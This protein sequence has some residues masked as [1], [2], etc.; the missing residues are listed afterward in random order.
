MYLGEENDSGCIY[1]YLTYAYGILHGS[2]WD[3]YE[4]LPPEYARIYQFHNFWLSEKLVKKETD[5]T[6]RG[7]GDGSGEKGAGAEEEMDGEMK[8]E[9]EEGEKEREDILAG[10]M[11]DDDADLDAAGAGA[12]FAQTSS[13]SSFLSCT[14]VEGRAVRPMRATMV[15]ITVQGVAQSD[16]D[17][18]IALQAPVPMWGLFR[19]E[20]K[21]SVLHA[22]VP[23][24]II[25]PTCGHMN[26]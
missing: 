8:G 10:V 25:A 2:A 5:I 19:Y 6:T 14:S 15:T 16:Y 3:K 7:G 1:I 13:S 9:D 26:L 24:D 21:I 22:Q 12:G 18:M 11:D 17:A 20:H 4:N 23:G